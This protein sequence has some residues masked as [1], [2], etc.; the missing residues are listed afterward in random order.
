MARTGPYSILAGEDRMSSTAMESFTQAE[1]TFENCF[2]CHD[3]HAITANGVPLYA[4]KDGVKLLDPG[5]LNVSHVRRNSSSKT[6]TRPET[7]TS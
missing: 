6:A 2:R 5:P 3:T 4:N 7:P 1:G